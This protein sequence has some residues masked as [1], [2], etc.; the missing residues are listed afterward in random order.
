MRK[1]WEICL[2]KQFFL[3]LCVSVEHVLILLAGYRWYTIVIL[4]YLCGLQLQF[5]INKPT[6]ETHFA[7]AMAMAMKHNEKYEMMMKMKP[8]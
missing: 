3:F 7:D 1:E 8:K 2:H 6:N 4:L 5:D